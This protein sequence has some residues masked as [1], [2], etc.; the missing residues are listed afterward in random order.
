VFL[1]EHDSAAGP[2]NLCCPDTP[3]NGEFTDALAAAVGRKARL[4]APVAVLRRA[5]GPM[6]PELLGSLNIRPAALEA[7]GFEFAD[8]DV[9]AIFATALA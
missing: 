4:S 2:V 9:E 3:T 5:A 8:R 1:A 6:A 7:L